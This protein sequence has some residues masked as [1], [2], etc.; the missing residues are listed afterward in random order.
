MVK[1]LSDDARAA[2]LPGLPA[3]TLDAARDGIAR[4]FRFK[5]FVEAFGFM[6]RVALL[7]EKADHHPEWSNVWNRV[8]I[9]LTTHDAGGLSQRDIDLAK[10]ID[11]L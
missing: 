1:K 4:S 11:A 2:L 7:A 3:W 10:A 9:L 8:D 5:D 6:S